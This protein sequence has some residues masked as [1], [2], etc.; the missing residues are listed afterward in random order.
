MPA[1]RS[2][3]FPFLPRSDAW[4]VMWNVCKELL[5][6]QVPVWSGILYIRNTR[7]NRKYERKTNK[8]ENGNTYGTSGKYEISFCYYFGCREKNFCMLANPY[9]HLCMRLHAILSWPASSFVLRTPKWFWFANQLAV[10]NNVKQTIPSLVGIAN[11][12]IPEIHACA[13]ARSYDS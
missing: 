3:N 13:S 8:R 7:K 1:Y 6:P 12:K 9:A 5:T 4:L 2:D 11:S 10:D